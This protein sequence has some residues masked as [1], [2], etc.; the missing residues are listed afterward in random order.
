M[1]FLKCVTRDTC[2]DC[3]ALRQEFHKHNAF[4]VPKLCAHDLPSWNGLFEFF[5]LL[6]MMCATDGRP[7]RGSSCTFLLPSSKSHPSPYHWITHGMF[8]IHLTMLI[9]NV[10]RFHVSCVQETDCRPHFT[11]GGLLNFLEHFKH[12][13]QCVN[14]VCLQM[15]SVPSKK[16]KTTTT[17]TNS[18]RM[19]TIVTAAFQRQYLQM[20]LILWIHLV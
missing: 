16:K 10:S 9:M 1:Q 7:F 13:G 5:S 14:I 12:T 15:A 11:C 4:S 2:I 19:H 6:A 17:T 3:W 8:S 20:E 18:A